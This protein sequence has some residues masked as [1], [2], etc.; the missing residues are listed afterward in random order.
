M[1]AAFTG[2]EPRIKPEVSARDLS[3][4]LNERT[5]GMREAGDASVAQ[6]FRGITEH[7]VLSDGLYS[8]EPTGVSTKPIKAAAEAFLG[9]LG[10][11]RADAMFPVDSDAWRRWSNVHMFLMRHGVCMEHMTERQKE[12]ALILMRETLSAAGYETARN[13][14]KL[15]ETIREITG[16]NLEFSDQL[17]WFS[18]FGEPSDTE[19][20]GWQVD[21]H[22]LIIN[23]FILGD[24]VVLSP[25]FFGSEPCI[26]TAGKYA[27]TRVFDAEQDR[28]LALVQ[29]LNQGQLG[30][31]LVGGD[32]PPECLIP[33]FSDN[34]DLERSGLRFDTLSAGQKEL[35]TSLIEAY[36]GRLRDGHSQVWMKDVEQHLDETYLAWIGGTGDDAVFYYRVHSPVIII[37]FDHQRGIA[38]NFDAPT[39]HHIHTVVRTPN[40]N[41][42]GRALLRQHYET[43]GHHAK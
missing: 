31:A 38:L 19:P 35:A 30:Q 8:I 18:I 40:G 7:G 13:I 42:Y 27:G 14:M 20:W 33:A 15:N 37:E 34:A 3:S 17:Y 29:S 22:H 26:A 6:P 39:R 43:S 23:C 25:Q 2:L 32:M 41:D 21:G 28:G 24:Q 9:S 12:D 36:V 5:K 11:K 16:R 4:Q 1:T 10:D